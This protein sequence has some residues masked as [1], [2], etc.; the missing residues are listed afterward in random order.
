METNFSTP[1]TAPPSFL[2]TISMVSDDVGAIIQS[3]TQAERKSPS[4]YEPAKELFLAILEEKLTFMKALEQAK[5]LPDPIERKCATDILIP[6]R[7]FLEKEPRSRIGPFPAMAID[8]PNDLELEVSPIWLRHLPEK[9]LMILHFWQ[10]PLS[11]RQL[12]AAAAILRNAL[13]RHRPEYLTC[14]LEFVSVALAANGSVRRF[15]RYGWD[16]IRPLSDIELQRFWK[17]FCDAWS[18]YKRRGPR[19]IRRRR[20]PG[21]FDR[22]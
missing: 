7:Q 8:L 14:E 19:Q 13:T 5:K 16:R 9:R 2:S 11:E 10:T 3:L 17:P 18:D 4:R 20:D 15:K 21:L 1:L 6:S 22:R 12:S